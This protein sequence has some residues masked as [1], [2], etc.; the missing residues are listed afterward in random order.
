MTGEVIKQF[1]VG[2]GFGVDE[3]SLKN[4][5]KAIDASL[6]KVKLISAAIVGMASGAFFGISKISEGFEEMGYATRMIA[7]AINK[8]ILLR[9]A[10]VAAYKDAG[11]NM[12]QAV[13][14]SI[15]FN[16][17]LAKTKFQLEGIVKSTAIKFLP[18]LT[19]QMDIFRTKVS[20]N[21]PKI[22]AL[23]ER[24]IKFIF[25]AFEGVVILGTRLW[26]MFGRLWDI[27]TTLDT[28]TGGWSTKI[29]ALAAA[30]KILNLSFLASPLGLILVGLLAIL[31]LYDDFMTWKE[32][33]ESLFDWGSPAVQTIM[34]V[35]AAIVGMVAIF[36]TA[37]IA[38]QAYRALMIGITA[39]TAAFKA[40]MAAVRIAML[41]GMLNPVG[42][43]VAAVAGLI[44]LVTLLIMKWD[45]IKKGI[46]GFF[47][48]LG[49]K[50]LDFVGGDVN[51][52]LTVSP[53]GSN[54]GN[55]SSQN[56]KQDTTI[57]VQGATDPANT[58]TRVANQ[59]DQV[60]FN[61]TRNMKGA[62]R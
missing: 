19:K 47:S 39:I 7:P 40:V 14:Q 41:L 15:K 60:N 27:L 6:T 25:K 45:T 49:G 29:L 42:L 54:G 2:L 11:I 16:M 46:G 22:L 31:A 58:A 4:F 5:G 30:W 24:F 37:M 56:V 48:G 59:Q 36:K 8:A 43:V 53:L 28:A 13:Q 33:G 51:K 52:N 62:A 55:S 12:V 23:L 32:G 18:M 35:V 9:K 21:M 50:V 61:M 44:A 34:G 3:K 57:I 38:M 20:A 1:L 10:M 26:S 17:S